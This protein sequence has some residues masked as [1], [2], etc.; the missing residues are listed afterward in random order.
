MSLSFKGTAADGK[1]LAGRT[2]SN[3]IKRTSNPLENTPS[4]SSSTKSPTGTSDI[5]VI[6]SP[7]ND[8]VYAASSGNRSGFFRSTDGGVTWNGIALMEVSA[9][10]NLSII[11][12]AIADDNTIFTLLWDDADASGTT[13]NGDKTM[14]FK[15]TNDG[16]NW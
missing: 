9:L 6:H 11:D 13:S 12:H 15:T 14:L 16:L 2:D 1:L 5:Q 3:I 7:L 8:K 10:S 4:W